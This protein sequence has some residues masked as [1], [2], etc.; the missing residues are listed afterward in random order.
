MKYCTHHYNTRTVQCRLLFSIFHHH[1]TSRIGKGQSSNG[2]SGND[3]LDEQPERTSLPI[4]SLFCGQDHPWLFSAI[5]HLFL[6]KTS[7][8]SLLPGFG[9][10]KNII[11]NAE[12]VDRVPLH[13][14]TALPC[15][16]ITVVQRHVYF[17]QKAGWKKFREFH[18]WKKPHVCVLWVYSFY[19]P[20]GQWN[21]VGIL[22]S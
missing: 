4:I 7:C 19:W 14:M 21:T 18:L 13:G 10:G 17:D 1:S 2:Y 15:R 5:F 8:C 11:A 12:P 20:T 3:Y 6:E 16:T 22:I 9:G